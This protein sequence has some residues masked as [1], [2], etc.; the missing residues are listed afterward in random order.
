MALTTYSE[1][2]ENF[3]VRNGMPS[4]DINL[5]K[6]PKQLKNEIDEIN[7]SKQVNL[8]S[9]TSIKTINGTSILGSGNLE[10]SFADIISKPTTISGYGIT[11]AYTKTEVE[12]KIVELAPPT[13]ISMK[14]DKVSTYTKTEVGTLAELTAILG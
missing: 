7:S 11:D 13:D 10:V 14:A 1:F 8:V 12:T 2:E 6:A 4:N 9:G 3:L 5:N